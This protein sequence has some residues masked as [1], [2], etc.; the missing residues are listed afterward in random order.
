M[1]ISI[2]SSS[3]ILD[4]TFF[5]LAQ[6]KNDVVIEIIRGVEGDC[7]AINDFRVAGPKPWGGGRVIARFKTTKDKIE[8]A[9]RKN[10]TS[11]PRT[12]KRN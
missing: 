11:D 5:I 1:D 3:A 12:A 6:M 2:R 4:K 7:V 9:M 8:E 10:E